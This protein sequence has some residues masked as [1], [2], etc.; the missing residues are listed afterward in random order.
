MDLAQRIME[1]AINIC[2][3]LV[4]EGAGVEALKVIRHQVG[5]RPHRKGGARIEREDIVDAAMGKSTVVHSYGAASY[6]YQASYGMAKDVV[7]IVQA[8]FDERR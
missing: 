6:G 2:P 5:Q 3:Q 7:G 8:Y 4:P 1:R